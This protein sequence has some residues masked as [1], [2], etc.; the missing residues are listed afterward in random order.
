M[1]DERPR[2]E[3]QKIAKEEET[4][5]RLFPGRQQRC[6]NILAL[7]NRLTQD[8]PPDPGDTGAG[9]VAGVAAL[10]LAQYVPKGIK[11]NSPGMG[12]WLQAAAPPQARLL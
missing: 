10:G 2:G 1:V 3:E 9:R 11:R 12:Q 6:L 8:L 5:R 7:P 4:N